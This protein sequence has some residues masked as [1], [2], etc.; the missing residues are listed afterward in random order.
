[1][2]RFYGTLHTHLQLEYSMRSILY[3]CSDFNLY[4]SVEPNVDRRLTSRL[5]GVLQYC[6]LPSL[7]G[8]AA[9][10]DGPERDR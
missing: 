9:V 1:M 5:R 8:R 6:T 7:A 10:G 3:F 2:D 4:V